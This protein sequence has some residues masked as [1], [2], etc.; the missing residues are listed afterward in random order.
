VVFHPCAL[1]PAA[2]HGWKTTRGTSAFLR[3]E[4]HHF[5]TG[6]SGFLAK[7]DIIVE[8]MRR[9]LAAPSIRLPERA[10]A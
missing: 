2:P 8:A 10:T 3:L 1:A 6:V 5:T 4:W 7:T 9:Y